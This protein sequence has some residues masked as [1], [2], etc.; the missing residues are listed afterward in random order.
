MIGS[1]SP[2]AIFGCAESV[3]ST[4]VVP[5]RGKPTTKIGW[6]TPSRTLARGSSASRPAVKKPARRRTSAAASSAM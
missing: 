5:E 4:I 1:S 3:C 2:A 6:A